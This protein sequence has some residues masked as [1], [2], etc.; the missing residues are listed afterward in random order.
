MPLLNAKASACLQMPI[1]IC[2]VDDARALL[3]IFMPFSIPPPVGALGMGSN[4]AFAIKKRGPLAQRLEAAL[5]DQS[6]NA[7]FSQRFSS[8]FSRSIV[9]YFKAS[10]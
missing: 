3:L 10:T 6:N 7:F 8:F 5:I 9:V 2:I 4:S 1:C